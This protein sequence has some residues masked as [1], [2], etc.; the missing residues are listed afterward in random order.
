MNLY[1]AYFQRHTWLHGKD[2]KNH[3]TKEFTSENLTSALQQAASMTPYGYAFWKLEHT[4][5]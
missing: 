4:E 5:K 1:K 2:K 3:F